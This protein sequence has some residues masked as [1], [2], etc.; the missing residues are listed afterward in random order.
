MPSRQPPRF[1]PPRK[2]RRVMPVWGRR[3]TRPSKHRPLQRLKQ[4]PPRYRALPERGG[5]LLKKICLLLTL[6]ALFQTCSCTNKPAYPEAMQTSFAQQEEQAVQ[7]KSG[8]AITAQSSPV[9]NPAPINVYRYPRADLFQN[10]QHF[11]RLI[12]HQDLGR[13]AFHHPSSKKAPIRFVFPSSVT[14][15]YRRLPP[16]YTFS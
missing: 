9:K 5:F 7:E 14:F 10:Q 2:K 4:K 13:S 11:L 1:P 15:R 3:C 8:S 6:T 16:G 12:L